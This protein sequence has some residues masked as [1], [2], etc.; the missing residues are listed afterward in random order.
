[1]TRKLLP[2]AFAVL[3]AAC[4]PPSTVIATPRVA[5]IVGNLASTLVWPLSLR[6]LFS[7]WLTPSAF[8]YGTPRNN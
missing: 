3:L 4:V 5:D 1:M 7:P 2:L 8:W 6:Y